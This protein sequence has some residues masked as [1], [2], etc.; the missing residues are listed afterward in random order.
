MQSAREEPRAGCRGRRAG[1][2][3]GPSLL[4]ADARAQLAAALASV[5]FVVIGAAEAIREALRPDQRLEFPRISRRN[6][7][8]AFAWNI[9]SDAPGKI[10]VVRLS[11]LGDIFHSLPG[12]AAL[13]GAFPSAQIDWLVQRK[14]SALLEGS[15]AVNRVIPVRSESDGSRVGSV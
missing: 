14:W 1:F 5:D 11:S 13:R 10:L 3:Q 15:P 7:S 9:V 4:G 8:S 2:R 12:A 6:S